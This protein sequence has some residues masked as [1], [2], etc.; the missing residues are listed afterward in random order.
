MRTVLAREHEVHR[1]LTRDRILGLLFFQS[2][3]FLLQFL[4]LQHF[5]LVLVLPLG[6]S[7]FQS[8]TTLIVFATGDTA[9]DTAEDR[10]GHH[11]GITTITHIVACDRTRNRSGDNTCISARITGS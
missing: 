5:L 11:V 10:T 6:F 3:N 8:F 2:F 9:N 4:L 7:G 1:L